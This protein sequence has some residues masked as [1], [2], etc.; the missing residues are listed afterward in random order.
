MASRR[1][2]KR[3]GRARGLLVILFLGDSL[4][5]EPGSA[6]GAFRKG[7][8]AQKCSQLHVALVPPLSRGRGPRQA[9]DRD[10]AGVAW[11]P[12][13]FGRGTPWGAYWEPAAPPPLDGPAGA[14]CPRASGN[15][16][17]LIVARL[18][19]GSQRPHVPPGL[20]LA[21]GSAAAFAAW[22]GAVPPSP[23][24]ATV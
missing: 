6:S 8:D 9:R 19:G 15:G 3:A 2:G 22:V 17:R 4:I 20:G 12:G 14:G 21:A 24:Q 10:R 5:R 1:A 11:P 18:Q 13:A 16:T 23:Q 7:L